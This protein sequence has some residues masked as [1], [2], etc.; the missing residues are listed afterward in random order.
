MSEYLVVDGQQR[1]TTI[2]LILLVVAAQARS[3]E[4]RDE[5]LELVT[6]SLRGKRMLRWTPTQL[7]TRQVADV[8]EEIE[9]ESGIEIALRWDA[10]GEPDQQL[11]RAFR[12]LWDRFDG[13][14][15]RDRRQLVGRLL[16]KCVI[17]VITV[18]L[19][20][21]PTQIFQSINGTG[22]PLSPADLLRNLV[23]HKFGDRH[24]DAEDFYHHTWRDLEAPLKKASL[25]Q[26]FLHTFAALEA[27]SVTVTGLYS[28]LAAR[29]S[30]S[31]PS[32][33][34]GELS[35]YRDY[36]LAIAG[37]KA[38]PIAKDEPE[39]SEAMQRIV[40]V[41]GA[42]NA[43]PYLLALVAEAGT[44]SKP[45]RKEVAACIRVLDSLF[46][47]RAIVGTQNTGIRYFFTGLYDTVGHDQNKLRE[48]IRAERNGELAGPS[49]AD[50]RDHLLSNDLYVKRPT[51]AALYL[52]ETHERT[53]DRTRV[54]TYA[55]L[56]AYKPTVDHVMPQAPKAG[57][58]VSPTRH[59]SKVNKIGNLI[60]ISQA[61]NSSKGRSSW[62]KARDGYRDERDFLRP[63]ELAE[64]NPSWGPTQ[65]DNRTKLLAKYCTGASGWPS[66]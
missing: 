61:K 47:R 11:W 24:V 57:W 52:L 7:D 6:Y 58:K 38:L 12:A 2:T 20:I 16:D 3:N 9:D 1:L 37:E 64:K 18:P 66:I 54:I 46:F 50:I 65:I 40:R 8:L 32:E 48:L 21:D 27:P 34:A 41:E 39:L 19:G 43:W 60:L 55:Q 56:A 35:E 5:M 13:A 28:Y 17:S 30:K 51:K 49:N 29:W 59:R 15:D 23:F 10:A 25:F 14:S 63:R 31:T 42:K 53:K 4:L 44:A 26:A 36:F 33:I 22:K 62:A 45:V